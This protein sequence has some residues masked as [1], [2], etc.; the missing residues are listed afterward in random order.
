MRRARFFSLAMCFCTVS[1][2]LPAQWQFGADV[3]ASRLQRT[4]IP[5]SN[6]LTVGG[7]ATNVGDRSWVRSS[8]LG[9]V[10]SFGQATAQGLVAGSLLSS[11]GHSMRG[12]LTGVLS[13]FGET[14]ASSTTSE[15]LMARG[16]IGSA[17]RG[18]AIGF[19]AGATAQSGSRNA[20]YHAAGDAWWSVDDNL[21]IGSAS[22]IRHSVT[23]ADGTRTLTLPRSYAD[24]SASWRRDRA[25]F[26][27]GAN[28]GV[29]GGLQGDTPGGAWGSLDAEAWVSPRSAVVL[30]GGRT[31]D[32]PVRGIPRTTFLSVALRFTGQ[33]HQTVALGGGEIV[34]A[35]ISIERIDE[36]HRRIEV[37]GVKASRVEVAGD[38]TDWTPMAMEA[39]GDAWRL[40]RTMSS[41]LHRIA[42]RIDGGEWMAPVNLP[43]ATDDLGGVVGLITVP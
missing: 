33:R 26:V 38:F 7:T 37:R 39:R 25:G 34:G 29:R 28:A 12:E 22:V 19:G 20:L 9:V 13:A 24:F 32:D 43:H 41:G 15:E 42:I 1:A 30:T 27:L 8:M 3:G 21:L 31:L 5:Q 4:D 10:S 36:T 35:R 17:L 16:Q 2:P 23:F 11:S 18:G 14:G 40:D 6:A